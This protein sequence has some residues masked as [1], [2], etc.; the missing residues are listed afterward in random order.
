MTD[1]PTDDEIIRAVKVLEAAMAAAEQNVF[2]VAGNGHYLV[3]G[4]DQMAY[5][6][7]DLAE[8]Y[9]EGGA[10]RTASATVH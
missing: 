6:I 10:E 1:N 3:I 4:R 8:P 9:L 2:A 5:E 7:A